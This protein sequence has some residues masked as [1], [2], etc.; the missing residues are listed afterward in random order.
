MKKGPEDTGFET[1]G[2][3]AEEAVGP[4]KSSFPLRQPCVPE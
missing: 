3:R 1:G 4:H 2:H